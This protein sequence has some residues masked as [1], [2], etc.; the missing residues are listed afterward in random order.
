MQKKW[1]NTQGDSNHLIPIIGISPITNEEIFSNKLIRGQ[2]TCVRLIIKFIN[3]RNV[4]S[5]HIGVRRFRKPNI[6]LTSMVATF[7]ACYQKTGRLTENPTPEPKRNTR[8]TR[9]LK[10]ERLARRFGRK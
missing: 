5:N 8:Q 10:R 9:Q 2:L 3:D 6:N 4:L 7:C 1:I